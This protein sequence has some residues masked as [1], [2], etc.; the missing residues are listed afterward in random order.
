[1]GTYLVDQPNYWN[2]IPPGLE[3]VIAASDAEGLMSSVYALG[4][5]SDAS[6]PMAAVLKMPPGYVLPRHAHPC[7]R[8]EVI[9][10]G[11]LAVGN[12]ILTA[13]DV[14]TAESGKFYGP[15]TAGEE[16]CI[17][18][19]VFSSRR[20]S[21]VLLVE[22]ESGPTEFDLTTVSMDSIPV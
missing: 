7:D 8:F 21:H 17:T 15:H 14:M 3:G 6:T 12:Q 16:G 9:V 22:T 20:G 11:S 5:D 18:V 1:M 2:R 19:E 13:G 4:A 10:Q